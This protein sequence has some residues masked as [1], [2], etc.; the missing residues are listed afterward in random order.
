MTKKSRPNFP[1]RYRDR[2]E[3]RAKRVRIK[4]YGLTAIMAL[5]QRVQEALS[6]G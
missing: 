5:N 2:R 3:V 1:M 4:P 6:R